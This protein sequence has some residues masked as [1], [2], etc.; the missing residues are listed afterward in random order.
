VLGT[1][2][3]APKR[4]MKSA[5][6][7]LESVVGRNEKNNEEE[8]EE[9]EK[10]GES[11]GKSDS[12]DGS[13]NN[14]NNNTAASSIAAATAT[15]T[16]ISNDEKSLSN[17]YVFIPSACPQN[18]YAPKD[19]FI[20][21]DD[22]RTYSKTKNK[23]PTARTNSKSNNNNGIND[24]TNTGSNRRTMKDRVRGFGRQYVLPFLDQVVGDRKEV[25]NEQE[26]VQKI[27]EKK[28]KE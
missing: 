11:D 16:N 19:C 13:N 23:D 28:S 12:E 5:R 6:D 24:N 1:E 10:V 25:E 2:F 22:N 14:N 3:E 27:K 9:E 18:N 20:A 8:E 26:L 17:D 15:A 4:V 21:G 7:K